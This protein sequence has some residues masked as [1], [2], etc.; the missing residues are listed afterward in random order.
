MLRFRRCCLKFVCECS[1]NR[2]N[3]ESKKLR[4][5]VIEVIYGSRNDLEKQEAKIYRC[6]CGITAVCENLGFCLSAV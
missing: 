4:F 1:R 2:S 6:L 5:P 3:L